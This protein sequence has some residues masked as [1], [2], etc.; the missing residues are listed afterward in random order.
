MADLTNAAFEP[1]NQ[2]LK[3]DPQQGKYMACC[4]LYRGDVVPRD[5]N[6]A[7]NAIRSKRTIQFVDW[8]PTGFK[9]GINSQAPVVVPGGDLGKV[10]RALCMLANTTAI[11]GKRIE[12]MLRSLQS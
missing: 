11:V 8:S 2:M 7:I 1:A 4:M 6:T 10:Q 3:C 12:Q 5:V 9:V